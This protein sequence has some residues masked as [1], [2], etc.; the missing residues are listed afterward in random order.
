MV[1][2]MNAVLSTSNCGI[3]DVGLKGLR[4][5]L[6]H[7][8]RLGNLTGGTRIRASLAFEGEDN[9]WRAKA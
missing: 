1:L 4:F 3:R 6:T 7:L 8:T 2:R 5:F 9:R